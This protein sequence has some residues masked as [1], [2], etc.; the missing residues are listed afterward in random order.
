ML[1]INVVTAAKENYGNKRDTKNIKYIVIHY[2]ANDGDADESNARYFQNQIV[3]ASAHY[4]VDD[5]STTQSVPDNFVAWSVGGEKYP[6]CAT[7]GGGKWYGTCT[8]NNSISVELCD[9]VRNGKNDFTEKTLANAAELVRSL[10]KKYNVPIENVI[11][12]FDVVG[13]VCPKPFVEDVKAWEDFK[14]R[15]VEAMEKVYNTINELP[16]WAKPTIQ[17]LIDK[18][19]LSGISD[20]LGL[21]ETA[22]KVFV[23]NDRAGLYG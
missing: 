16:K 19:Y 2:T 9:V 23:V 20:G 6:S 7:T 8:N 5:N 10:M 4:F 12:H 21:T 17:K 3:E 13:K 1:K 22:V 14:E 18:G 11:R 15:L